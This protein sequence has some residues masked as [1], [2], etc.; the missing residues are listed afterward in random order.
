M[1]S[2]ILSLIALL[3]PALSFGA[4]FDG[5]QPSAVT[6]STWTQVQADADYL[7]VDGGN[8]QSGV[9]TNLSSGTFQDKLNVRGLLTADGG[10]VGS[11]VLINTGVSTLGQVNAS[12]QVTLLSTLTVQGAA[13]LATGGQVVKV[14]NGSDTPAASDTIHVSS[15]GPTAMVVRDSANN[16][17]LKIE[18]TSAG[19]YVYGSG[20]LNLSSDTSGD[21]F[22]IINGA[23]ING[24]FYFGSDATPDDTFMEITGSGLVSYV[25]R[26]SSPN[27]S[28]DLMTIGTQGDVLIA[29]IVKPGIRTKAQIDTLPG[30]LG[31]QVMC[32]DCTVPYDVC[33]GT[34][35]GV[36][37]WRAVLNS[38]INTA[39][40][41]TLVSKGCGTGQ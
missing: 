8:A 10:Y 18:V 17:Q 22:G 24:Q 15:E 9:F 13:S 29:G 33:V 16:K 3:S 30:I 6:A 37:Q 39:V 34:G 27:G 31:G 21:D 40:P 32:S 19:T 5:S 20:M 36:S 4:A 35:T 38:A 41:G 2:L 26:V 23:V 25:V 12:G 1:K 14:G 28:T 7:Q 11:G